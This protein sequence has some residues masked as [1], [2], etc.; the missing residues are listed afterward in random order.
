MI[1][2]WSRFSVGVILGLW[3]ASMF[4][5]GHLS[6][7]IHE[8]KHYILSQLV[9]NKFKGMRV[10]KH[11]GHVVYHY[12]PQTEKYNA[13]I[14]LAPYWFPLFTL[15]ALLIALSI[16]LELTK[17]VL[18]IVGFGYGVDLL[19]NIRD[20]SPIQTDLTN[21]NGGYNV[22]L[23]FVIAM[24]ATLCTMLIAWVSLGTLGLKMLFTGHWNFMVH[25][26]SYYRGL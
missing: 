8:L 15:P 13:L 19:L 20:I 26:V 24:N 1:P 9:G 11:S 14:A 18:M 10:R 2:N 7:S 3:F 6:V 5:K 12:T 21:I 23:A 16:S 22:G 4:I 25:I 17:M